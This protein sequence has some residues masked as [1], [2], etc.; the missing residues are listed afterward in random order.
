MTGGR[1]CTTGLVTVRAGGGGD[2]G[3][4]GAAALAEAEGASAAGT[5]VTAGSTDGARAALA[6]AVA[7]VAA[8]VSSVVRTDA[9]TSTELPDRA[10]SAMNATATTPST[11]T[12]IPTP[13]SKRG[14]ERFF[15]SAPANV[16]DAGLIV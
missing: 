7:T 3:A 4:G 9:D 14:D 1:E 13:T 6:A 10:R 15:G 11:P 12:R 8:G 2:A 16:R 5:A